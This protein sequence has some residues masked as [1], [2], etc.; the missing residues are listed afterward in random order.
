MTPA[1][2]LT[3]EESASCGLTAETT[4]DGK[5]LSWAKISEHSARNA[6]H[7]AYSRSFWESNVRRMQPLLAQGKVKGAVD[8][9]GE[10]EGGNLKTT[11]V[12]WRRI[13]MGEGKSIYGAYEVV[14][15]HSAGRDLKALKDAGGKLGWSTLSFCEPGHA[16]SPEECKEY[17]FS[18]D[19]E[20]AVVLDRGEVQGIDA[21]SSPSCLSAWD[22]SDD[23]PPMTGAPGDPAMHMV[24]SPQSGDPMAPTGA[25]VPPTAYGASTDPKNRLSDDMS[26]ETSLYE[27]ASSS[28]HLNHAA[29]G[30]AMAAVSAGQIDHGSFSGDGTER[31]SANSNKFLGVDTSMSPDEKGHWKFPIFTG[32][33]VS[34]KGVATA[35]HY[36]EG[37]YPEIHAACTR[38]SDAI[39]RKEGGGDDKSDSNAN[40]NRLSEGKD[41]IPTKETYMNIAEF[42]EKNQALHDEIFNLGKA[43]GVKAQKPLVDSLNALLALPQ[44]KALEGLSI[45]ER[46]VLPDEFSKQMEAVKAESAAKDAKVSAA[47]AKV[48]E[49]QKIVDAANAEKAKAE[50]SAAIAA[51]V[52]ELTKDNAF[53]DVLKDDVME[54]AERPEFKVDDVEPL[55]K[56][57]TEKYNKLAPKSDKA[58]GG[59]N[60]TEEEVSEAEEAAESMDAGG[61]YS[62]VKPMKVTL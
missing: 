30:H 21:V 37:T 24:G 8:H 18:E 36:A 54:A 26:L 13:V 31:S 47:E 5:K 19:D 45:P 46:E 48:A 62:D 34:V 1:L 23:G 57:K 7:R 53:A 10:F 41:N 35:A 9:I 60:L 59:A 11:P 61:D 17:G 20:D 40:P 33:K 50:R 6:N 16:P 44:I 14:E 15:A 32:N 12:I 4:S 22:L 56:R 42:K 27:S 3:A 39:K 52:A 2:A 43:E 28:V 49:L 25:S 29:V 51:K 55:I 58:P 38:I